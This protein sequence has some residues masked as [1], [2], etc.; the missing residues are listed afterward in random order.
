MTEHHSRAGKRVERFL[1]NDD[2]HVR[3]RENDP[4]TGERLEKGIPILTRTPRGYVVEKEIIYQ[5]IKCPE[6]RTPARFSESEE[7][8]CPD[9]GM[10]CAGKDIITEERMVRDAKA[11]GRVDG[12]EA[13]TSA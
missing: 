11:A 10:V 4:W 9:C 6:C 12:D 2:P 1:V 8:L 3:Y 5:K 13:N 7:P